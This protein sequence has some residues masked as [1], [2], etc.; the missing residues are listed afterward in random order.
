MTMPSHGGFMVPH[1]WDT[2]PPAPWPDIT[3]HSVILSWDWANQSLC[4]HTYAYGLAKNRQISFFKS[5]V[6]LDHGSHPSI[7]QHGR[8]RLNKGG[9]PV[10][11]PFY[12][13]SLLGCLA[14]GTMT[15]YPSQSYFPTNKS[16]PFRINEKHRLG[17]DEYQFCKWLIW[18]CRNP[19]PEL[20]VPGAQR[21]NLAEVRR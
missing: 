18:L 3:A 4:Y 5:P 1:H 2:M 8:L 7:S 19:I 20:L 11:S 21:S 17:R 9:L 15:H 14:T 10:W 12:R 6:C 13:A 16:L